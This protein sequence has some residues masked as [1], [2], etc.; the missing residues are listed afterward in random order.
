[1]FEEGY[2]PLLPTGTILHITGYMDNSV[3]NP[4]VADSRNWQGSG[5][6]SLANMFIDLGLRVSMSEERFVQEVRERVE[7]HQLTKNDYFIGCPLCLAVVGTP[8]PTPVTGGAT[9]P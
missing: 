6:R 3:T 9:Q 4:N 2:Q 8:G 1:V 7:R 5:N